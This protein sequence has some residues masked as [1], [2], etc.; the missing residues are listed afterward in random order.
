MAPR[1][2]K[3]KAS[4][5]TS[6]QTATSSP[7]SKPAGISKAKAKAAPSS[8]GYSANHLKYFVIITESTGLDLVDLIPAAN[9]PPSMLDNPFDV[10]LT[11]ARYAAG[12][13]RR[14]GR[15]IERFRGH[16]Q[17]S[18]RA[19]SEDADPQAR[20]SDFRMAYV[21]LVV[22]DLYYEGIADG[23]QAMEAIMNGVYD[24]LMERYD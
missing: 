9:L 6:S 18:I 10:P 1:S 24:P 7:G 11:F 23:M 5:S 20:V 13:A 2:D 3:A 21:R 4:G 8:T 15:N 17:Q 19:R 22:Q 14:T 16:L 12:L